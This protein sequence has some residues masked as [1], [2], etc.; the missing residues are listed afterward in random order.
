MTATLLLTGCSGASNGSSGGGGKV[1]LKYWGVAENTD[2]ASK[3]I[4][5]KFEKL[6]PNIQVQFTGYPEAQYPTKIDTAL[7]AG[8]PPDVG[9]MASR[10]WM[11][12]GRVLPLDDVAAK[13]HIDVANW[14][15]GIVGDPSQPNT[16]PS[17]S[18]N[19]KLYCLG[20]YTGAVM[21]L[22]NADMYKAAHITPPPAWPPITVDQYVKES[23]Q[24]TRKGVYGT[25]YGDPVTFLPWE[26]Y[27]S[28]DGKTVA[29]HMNSPQTISTMQTLADGIKHKC[30]PSLSSAFD[31]W[32]QGEDF[33]AEGKLASVIAGL[34]NLKKYEK[35][36]IH[37]GFA[38]VPTQPGQVPYFSI[39]TDG[40]GVFKGS[41]HSAEAKE[42]VAFVATQ[43]QRI[44]SEI[45][46]DPPLDLKVASDINW[47][48]GIPGRLQG[49]EILKHARPPVF[50]PDRWSVYGP[51]FDAFGYVTSGKK[52]AQQAYTD[53]V[54]AVQDN[55]NKAWQVWDK[56]A[57][58]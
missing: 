11:R 32:Q 26:M 50:I 48:H 27:A 21:L 43:G 52:T 46:G 5:A 45:T 44:R 56:A 25:A 42:F 54:P 34:D 22:Y 8:S 35:A 20:T 6:H 17:C 51:A 29:G 40:I 4:I 41:A 30:A 53:A 33:F 57:Q 58:K 36:G 28:S 15:K 19:G 1:V 39:W 12:A 37:Y 3:A 38:P 10:T 18:Y 31:P 2:K 14:N 49:L 24:L 47:A 23:C 9:D 7:A 13:D 55:L 16:E